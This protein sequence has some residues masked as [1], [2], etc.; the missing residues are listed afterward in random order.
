MQPQET[1]PSPESRAWRQL[2]L[3]NG[4]CTDFIDHLV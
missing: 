1:P 3:L 4:I 2:I